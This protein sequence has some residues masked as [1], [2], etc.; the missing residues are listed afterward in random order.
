LKT[1]ATKKTTTEDKAT[2][3]V[4]SPSHAPT[5]TKTFIP[6]GSPV[7]ATLDNEGYFARRRGHTLLPSPGS[8]NYRFLLY[9]MRLQQVVKSLSGD[10]VPQASQILPQLYISDLYTATSP[11]TLDDLGI[12]H[13]LSL[14]SRFTVLPFN[15]PCVSPLMSPESESGSLRSSASSPPLPTPTSPS[16]HPKSRFHAMSIMLEDVYDSPPR[17]PSTPFPSQL[18]QPNNDLLSVLPYTTRFIQ[19]ALARKDAVNSRVLVHCD[20][21][22]SVS[23]AVVLG[24][25]IQVHYHSYEKALEFLRSRRKLAMPHPVFEQQLKIWEQRVR[26]DLESA[27]EIGLRTRLE[28]QRR[29]TAL[30]ERGED[31][32][33]C[34]W[35]QE[36]RYRQ[37]SKS[38]QFPSTP[39]CSPPRSS[40]T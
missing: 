15:S 36:Y 31:A 37:H 25:L 40:G 20:I 10:F 19:G 27:L 22:K 2:M 16:P 28:G 1:A 6:V 26:L 39:P 14:K 21:G 11:Q 34:E 9:R 13:I 24:Y 23:A 7:F 18:P 38:P 30:K 35:D 17:T 33:E 4:L 12:T 5:A 3:A 32:D 8:E 29:E